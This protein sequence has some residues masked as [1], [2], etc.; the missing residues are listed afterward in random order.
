LQALVHQVISER[1]ALI[2]Y[3]D[4]GD[5]MGDAEDEGEIVEAN[6]NSDRMDTEDS[7][8]ETEDVEQDIQ[9]EPQPQVRQG[10]T[11][12]T[13]RSLIDRRQETIASEEQNQ[14]R[15]ANSGTGAPP[16]NAFAAMPQALLSTGMFL[17]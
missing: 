15:S 11:H 2:F 7:M 3:R 17:D 5:L 13:R 6:G 1:V 4:H 12:A 9:A 8:Q 16:D 14:P 10:S